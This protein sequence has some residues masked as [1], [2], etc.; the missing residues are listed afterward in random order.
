MNQ[1]TQD[2]SDVLDLTPVEARDAHPIA[3]Q[4]STALA[5]NSP[6]AMMMAAMAQGVS[7]EQ[8]GKMMDLQE[9][10]ERREAEKAYN[11][12]FAAFKAEA[13]R[14]LKNREVTAGPL[15]GKSYAELHSVVN[16]V[17]P[18]LSLH[19]LSASWK[20]TRD[21]PQWLEVT[22]VLKHSG[23]HSESVSMGGPP[24][25]GGAK[26]AIQA[27]A[28]TKSYLE[29]YTLKA[30]CG[31]AEGGDDDD[32]AGGADGISMLDGWSGKA[33]ACEHTS[34]LTEVSRAGV[35]AFQAARDREGYAKFAAIVQ[36]H[37]ATLRAKEPKNA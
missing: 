26:N 37:G 1:A 19:G 27:R 24:D 5:V 14:I 31:V 4:A 18:A 32:G 9:R 16:A 22:C 30:I 35:K 28:S 13:I 36:S 15:N 3:Q 12:A 20:L 29:R 11:V 33:Y 10:W 8:V 2:V 21:E 6:V 17:T 7:P 34:A 25:A 23:G